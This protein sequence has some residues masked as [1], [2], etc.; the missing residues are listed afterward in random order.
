MPGQIQ[1]ILSGRG[2][3]G[4]G[5]A[6]GAALREKRESGWMTAEP[7]VPVHVASFW[8]PKTES[9]K[10]C[11]LDSICGGDAAGVRTERRDLICDALKHHT[12]L[13]VTAVAN[14]PRLVALMM[15]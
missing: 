15:P 11:H 2:L 13:I 9:S 14:S 7:A 4:R 6:V 5:E 1:P 12:H 8:M 3:S 10:A